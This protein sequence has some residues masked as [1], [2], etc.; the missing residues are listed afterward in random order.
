MKAITLYQANDLSRFENEQDCLKY[1]QICLEVKEAIKL[2]SEKNKILD[3]RRDIRRVHSPKDVRT[4]FN[5][6]MDICIKY[7]PIH[8]TSFNNVKKGVPFKYID[9]MIDDSQLKC[10]RDTFYRFL[11]INF[12]SGYE[13]CM[14]SFANN[15]PPEEWYEYFGNKSK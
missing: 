10:L 4:A 5:N 7:I 2:I 14:P 11:C 15:E 1:E 8:K 12:N 13:Y 9:W 3:S 6:F